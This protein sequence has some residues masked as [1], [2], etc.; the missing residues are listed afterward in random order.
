MVY[1]T[2]DLLL[3]F[4]AF[5]CNFFYLNQELVF[6]TFS[7]FDSG[8]VTNHLII[9]HKPSSR[10]AAANIVVRWSFPSTLKFNS[11]QAIHGPQY[12]GLVDHESALIVKVTSHLNGI[13]AH[14]ELPA[15]LNWT[16][17]LT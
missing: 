14:S 1:L 2:N 15:M 4:L 6:L 5:L 7:F 3:Y 8:L 10:G 17:N 12:T 13:V 11:A 16:I 9:A